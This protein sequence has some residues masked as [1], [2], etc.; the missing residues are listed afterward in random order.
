MVLKL[1]MCCKRS[2]SVISLLWICA[3][4]F[5][6]LCLLCFQRCT[7][8][9]GGVRP[10]R[11]R[12]LTHTCSRLALSGCWWALV[13]TLPSARWFRQSLSGT[14]PQLVLVSLVLPRVFSCW[15]L[16]KDL[17]Q[18]FAHFA[19]TVDHVHLP[20]APLPVSQ[21]PVSYLFSS[22]LVDSPARACDYSYRY[23]PCDSL[24]KCPCYTTPCL[25]VLFWVQQLLKNNTDIP[26]SKIFK[27][28]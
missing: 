10:H 24:N 1:I 6:Y 21:P 16:Q 28:S 14:W 7:E 4:V 20:A 26:I 8:G 3:V 2:H 5:F 17:T 9:L 11:S 25:V 12:W 23:T 27:L 13:F 19:C 22:S 18:F 15:S